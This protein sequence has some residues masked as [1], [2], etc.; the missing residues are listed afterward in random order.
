MNISVVTASTLTD[1]TSDEE[2]QGM[3]GPGTVA[4]ATSIAT[5]PKSLATELELAFT[6]PGTVRAVIEEAREGADAVV[7]D[8]MLDPGLAA[9]REAVEVPVV[10]AAESGMHLAAMLAHEFSIVTV[11]DTIR[12]SL[13]QGAERYGLRSKLASVRAVDLPMDE[14]EADLERLLRLLVEQSVAA[15]EDDGA[16]A[17]LFGC[18]GMKSCVTGLERELAQ[19]GYPGVP[20]VDPLPAAVKMAELLVDLQL[21]QSR[22]TYVPPLT[23]DFTGYDELI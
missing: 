15:I 22:L 12:P 21:S 7:I 8:C 4:K 13:E 5:G 20:V 10:G 1:L 14:F 6:V 17:I 3:V 11:T 9:A 2:I 23:R 19:R 16:H 18:T